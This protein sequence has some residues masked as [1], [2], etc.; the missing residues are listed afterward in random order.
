MKKQHVNRKHNFPDADLYLQ[1][2]ERI[3]YAHRDISHFNTYGYDVERL[4]KFK[5]M[6]NKFR[7]LPDDDELVGDQMVLTE[8]SLAFQLDTNSF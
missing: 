7:E 4:K 8:K 3:R 2:M 5:A 6:C 1:C